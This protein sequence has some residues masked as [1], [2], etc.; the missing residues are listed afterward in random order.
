ML[1]ISLITMIF[2]FHS[3]TKI[4]TSAFR[5]VNILPEGAAG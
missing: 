5:T 1:T 3:S 4:A 2:Y